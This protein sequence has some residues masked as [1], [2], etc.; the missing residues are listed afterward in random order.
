VG[1]AETKRCNGINRAAVRGMHFEDYKIM[2]QPIE[3]VEADARVE[4]YRMTTRLHQ[5][6]V[7]RVRKRA[8]SSYDDKR[9][10]AD[11]GVET[12]AH[13]YQPPGADPRSWRACHPTRRATAQHLTRRWSDSLW[14]CPKGELAACRGFLKRKILNEFQTT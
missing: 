2:V 13:G 6:T 9:W 8:L 4:Q 7:Q 5:V 1:E 14:G 3:V 12:H 10:I 11:D